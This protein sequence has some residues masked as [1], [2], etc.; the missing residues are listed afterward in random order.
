MK[1]WIKS[2]LL[3][4]S[5]ASPLWGEIVVDQQFLTSKPRYILDYPGDYIA[6]TFTVRNTGK[7]VGIGIQVSVRGYQN[8]K[9]VTDDLLVRLVRADVSG[10]PAIDEVLASQTVPRS[11]VRRSLPADELIELD[12]RNA[13]ALV[14]KGDILAIALSSNHTYYAH[15]Y[16]YLDYVWHGEFYDAHPGGDFYIYSPNIYGLEPRKVVDRR[17][18]PNSSDMA[19][20]ITINR[21][22][23]PASIVLGAFGFLGFGTV[24]FRR[25]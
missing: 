11:Q 7:V 19:F 13:N 10:V 2:L 20:R 14:H 15:P 4:C 3:V 5:F 17:S 9:P 8:Y 6:Q 1:N 22:P 18:P 12:V 25:R 23:E 24:R 21:V 16:N